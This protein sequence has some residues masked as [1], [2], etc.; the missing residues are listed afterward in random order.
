M[1]GKITNHRLKAGDVLTIMCPGGGGLGDPRERDPALV[2]A[3]V[4]EGIVSVE[5]AREVYRV[6]LNPDRTGIDD[7]AT[8]VLRRG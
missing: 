8:E 5:A 2:L 4:E 3:D 1:P 7:A 6:V